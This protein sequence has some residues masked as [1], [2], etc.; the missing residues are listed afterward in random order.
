MKENVVMKG[1][2]CPILESARQFIPDINLLFIHIPRTG[3][4]FI[5]G[6]L[7]KLATQ[8]KSV[9][10]GR[11]SGHFALIPYPEEIQKYQSFTVVRN[12]YDRI[13]SFVKNFFN[14][15]S[16]RPKE[17]TLKK[18][19]YPESISD[20]IESL[21]DLYKS[22][23][24]LWQQ[25][26]EDCLIRACEDSDYF[27]VHLTP[28]V[29][30]CQNNVGDIGIDHILKYETLESDFLK[31][32]GDLNLDTNSYN[33]LEQNIVQKVFPHCERIKNGHNFRNEDIKKIHEIYKVDFAAFNYEY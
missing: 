21:Y 2:P 5:E 7:Q 19:N 12:P 31:M 25:N 9:K 4:S 30:Y 28:Q 1:D 3:G 29:F 24:L 27:Y 14:L 17:N 11:F 15:Q 13:Y 33:F 32:L 23:K 16:S 22:T 6:N 8:L 10:T 20:F 18:L 26:G